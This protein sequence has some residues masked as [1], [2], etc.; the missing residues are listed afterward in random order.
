MNIHNRIKVIS[1][2]IYLT[3]G[4]KALY[5]SLPPH[6]RCSEIIFIDVDRFSQI[7]TLL[8]IISQL[9]PKSMIVGISREG[10]LS[11]QLGRVAM[12]GIEVRPDDM[13]A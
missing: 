6:F 9:D 5:E 3:A 2:D 11:R 10:V 8:T 4:L 7:K 13:V 1:D 12:M